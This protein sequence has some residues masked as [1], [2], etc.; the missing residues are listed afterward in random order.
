[1]PSTLTPP[2]RVPTSAAAAVNMAVRTRL[3]PEPKL[4]TGDLG[5]DI[6]DLSR[7]NPAPPNL[8]SNALHRHRVP[9][10]GRPPRDQGSARYRHSPGFRRHSAS[11]LSRPPPAKEK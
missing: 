11:R 6:A 9:S 7:S 2:T 5:S 4:L 1:M 10:H 3:V 8:Q